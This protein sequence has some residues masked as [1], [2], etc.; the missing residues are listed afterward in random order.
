V[1]LAIQ[2]MLKRYAL[3]GSAVEQIPEGLVNQTFLLRA[4]L[5]GRFVLQEV[6]PIFAKEVHLNIKAVTQHLDAQCVLTPRLVR[7]LDQALWVEDQGRT[8]RV[9]TYVDGVSH[10]RVP[11]PLL[12]EQCGRMLGR[13]HAALSDLT[14]TFVA[15]RFAHDTPKHFAHLEQVLSTEFDHVAYESVA[16]EGQ[17]LRAL[18]AQL[19]K[20]P[21]TPERIVHGDPKASNILFHPAE[22]V[23]LCMVDL[24]TVGRMALPLELGDAFRSWC[25]PAGEDQA[26]V[27][28]SL[29]L[30]DAALRGYHDEGP[31]DL[32]HE[33]VTNLVN[34]T[35]TITLELA[36]R[37]LADALTESYFA[38][39]P[40]TYA[41]RSEHN[42]ARTRSQLGLAES[43]LE[44]KDVAEQMVRRVFRV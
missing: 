19:P 11:S 16:R 14:Y 34:G 17:R 21:S 23:A 12:A 28:F 26:G 35:L 27:S 38:W 29:E 10:A 20:L 6:N 1:S 8:W 36:S 41:T 18:V 22:P 25:N 5:G 7:T 9:L 24:D 2:N 42:L 3:E 4:P 44:R 32:I 39:N 37:F 30:F 15:T 31:R 40:K 43:I 33:E 13:F